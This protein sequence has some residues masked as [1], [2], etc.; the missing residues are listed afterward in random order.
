MKVLHY[1]SNFLNYSETFIRRLINHQ[2][3]VEPLAMC[4]NKRSFTDICPV[5][6]KPKKGFAGIINFLCFHLNWNLPFYDQT[7]QKTKPE[8][9]HA[10]FGYDGY[11]MITASKKANIPLV[12]SFYGSDVSRL[13]TEFDWKR[14]YRK[15]S[16]HGDVFI[17]ASDLMKKQLAD[18]NFPENKTTV[19]RFGLDLKQFSFNRSYTPDSNLMMVGRMVEKK[20]FIYALRAIKI[21]HDRGNSFMLDLYGDGPLQNSLQKQ[22]RRWNIDHLIHFQGR[23]PIQVIRQAYQSHSLLIAPSV[24]AGDGDSEGIPNTLLEGMA[25][26][27][28]VIGTRH[29][30]IPEVVTHKKT[31]LLVDEKNASALA[32]MIL[33]AKKGP[34]NL[35][36][37]RENAREHIKKHYEIERMVNEVENIYQQAI[38]KQAQK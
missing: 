33:T 17:A 13:P 19:V 28:P 4:I 14:R 7:I 32:E 36:V 24:T 23:Q 2:Q 37:L 20:G 21:L 34:I 30:A 35:P 8:L 6:E 5:F 1:K 26:G 38:D 10:H 22:A 9:I 25:S 16:T 15:L 3:R 18:L 12:V 11:R 27:I 29:S 31:G